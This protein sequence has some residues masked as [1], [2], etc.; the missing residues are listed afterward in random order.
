[1][2]AAQPL[3]WS[4]ASC[5]DAAAARCVGAAEHFWLNSWLVAADS[6]VILAGE[7]QRLGGEQLPLWTGQWLPAAR[8][9]IAS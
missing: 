6:A 5:E 1:V 7:R 8:F 4:R 9:K 3:P 2:T